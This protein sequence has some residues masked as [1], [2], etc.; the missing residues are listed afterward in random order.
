MV[1]EMVRFWGVI[2][3]GWC[4]GGKMGRGG[5][6]LVGKI[7]GGVWTKCG[8]DLVVDR[9]GMKGQMR[10]GRYVEGWGRNGGNE[11]KMGSGSEVRYIL[12]ILKI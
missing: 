12:W 8:V 11:E 2:L 10:L 7:G 4:R 3:S 5:G 6:V 1:G 9:C